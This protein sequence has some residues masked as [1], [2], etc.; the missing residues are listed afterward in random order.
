M[1]CLLGAVVAMV[2]ATSGA[3]AEDTPPEGAPDDDTD[4]NKTVIVP[5]GP[6]VTVVAPTP[7]GGK[8]TAKGCTEVKVEGAPTVIVEDSTKCA[9]YKPYN[10]PE[11]VRIVYVY[12]KPPRARFA[13]DGSR[14]GLI[15]FGAIFHA[16]GSL[17]AWAPAN[18][19][20]NDRAWALMLYTA[21][22]ALA[23]T[24]ARLYVGST[25]SGVAYAT[26]ISASI[27]TGY[28]VETHA[29]ERERAGAT[30][31]LGF[32]APA[33]LG[34]MSL[35]TTPHRE[36]LPKEKSSTS[37]GV[38]PVVGPNSVGGAAVGMF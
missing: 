33:F 37:V 1:R 16:I 8:V 6:G 7:G 29:S 27:V 31:V 9:P 14:S 13:P 23:P 21:N 5:P 11:K 2:L 36:D 34:V 17:F 12:D 3:R 15:V 4:G 20:P 10:P 19:A 28:L 30:T 35:A 38:V 22:M 18:A 32:L 25:A 24:A 26:A